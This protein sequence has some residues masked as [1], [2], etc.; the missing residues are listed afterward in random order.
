M[1]ISVLFL[2]F[3]SS[4]LC[5]TQTLYGVWEYYTYQT[6]A[7]LPNTFP[8]WFG[9]AHELQLASYGHTMVPQYARG[10]RLDTSLVSAYIFRMW[11]V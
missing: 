2:F 7:L 10:S 4:F 5:I 3:L 11:H 1:K 9:M 6:I 8:F